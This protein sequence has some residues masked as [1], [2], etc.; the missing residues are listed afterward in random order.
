MSDAPSEFKACTLTAS[1][2]VLLLGTVGTLRLHV[3]RCLVLSPS[4]PP[5]RFFL[6]GSV[7]R[8]L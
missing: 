5:D 7:F 1:W 6:C 3:Q 4:L 2:V 8:S